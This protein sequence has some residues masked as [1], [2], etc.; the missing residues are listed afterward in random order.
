MIFCTC[1]ACK[2]KVNESKGT[3]AGRVQTSGL[4][5]RKHGFC[6]N[7]TNHYFVRKLFFHP[8]AS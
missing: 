5:P 3:K 6:P 1:L 7:T 8:L 4:V 2:H